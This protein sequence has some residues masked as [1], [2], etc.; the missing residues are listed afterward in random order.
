MPLNNILS[1]CHTSTTSCCSEWT[2]RSN[3]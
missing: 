3:I 2:R 1:R